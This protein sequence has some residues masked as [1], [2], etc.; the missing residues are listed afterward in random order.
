MPTCPGSLVPLS[1]RRYALTPLRSHGVTELRSYPVTRLLLIHTAPSPAARSASVAGSGT[2]ISVP[3]KARV[4]G[5]L[6]FSLNTLLC[7]LK[8]FACLAHTH[9]HRVRDEPF[10]PCMKL[11]ALVS[12][13]MLAAHQEPSPAPVASPQERA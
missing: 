9:S 3:V 13:I 5:V 8:R 7:C 11:V 6:A 1:L 12:P 4:T 10:G 2:P